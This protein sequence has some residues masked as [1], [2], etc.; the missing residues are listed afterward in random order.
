M[1]I[2]VVHDP[3]GQKFTASIDS[4][5][6]VL[7][8]SEANNIWDVFELVVSEELRGH[9]IAEKLCTAAFKY[10][11]KHGIKI[12]PTCTYVNDDFLK[13][14]PEYKEMTTDSFY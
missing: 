14:H 1:E 10:A 3:V 8:Y 2:K 9:G 11:K 4:H 5:E 7:A 6:S 13:K 12:I